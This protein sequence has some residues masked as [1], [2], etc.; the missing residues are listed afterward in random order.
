MYYKQPWQYEELVHET[1]KF[2]DDDSQKIIAVG[3]SL[4][5]QSVHVLTKFLKISY[6]IANQYLLVNIPV[7]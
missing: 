1:I 4:R 3:Y 2:L 6:A 7:L 5:L